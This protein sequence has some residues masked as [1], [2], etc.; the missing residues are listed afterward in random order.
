MT[1]VDKLNKIANNIS[2]I[3]EFTKLTD[4]V[5]KNENFRIWSGSHNA[6]LHHHGDGGLA[7]HTLEV[8]ELSLQNNRYYN[9]AVGEHKVFL[10]ALYHDFG[11]LWDYEKTAAGWVKTKHKLAIGHLCRSAIEWEVISRKVIPTSDDWRQEITHAILAHHGLKEWG[12][13]AQPQSQLAWILHLSDMMSARMDDW[14]KDRG[15][16]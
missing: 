13:P 14:N 4:Y 2:N 11:K 15:Q 12:S 6:N 9:F 3:L 8:V 10:A 1:P 7:Q 16:R 5:L